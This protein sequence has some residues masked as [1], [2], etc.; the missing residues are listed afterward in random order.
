MFN[1]ILKLLDR[2]FVVMGA[3]ICIQAPLFMQQYHQQLVG[4]VDELAQQVDMMHQVAMESNKSLEQFI[5]KFVTNNDI[6]FSRQG[7][8]MKGMVD[9]WRYLSEGLS[10]VDNASIWIKPFVFL[11]YLDYPI[12]H[13]TLNH[14]QFG[15]IL[16]YEGLI[17][18][19]IGI[20]VGYLLYS[21]LCSVVKRLF[22]YVSRAFAPK[23]KELKA[24]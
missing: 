8:I 15:I 1:W 23:S 20:C 24:P 9:R 3:L 6:D 5:F 7:N 19:L 21:I 12:A 11:Q 13:S 18:A 16:T 17:Y 14:Y 10:S 22:S 4:R 2:I